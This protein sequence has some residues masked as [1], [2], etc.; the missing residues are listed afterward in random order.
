MYPMSDDVVFFG[1]KSVLSLNSFVGF[2]A[3][4][5]VLKNLLLVQQKGVK[6]QDLEKVLEEEGN[7]YQFIKNHIS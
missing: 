3:V 7:G 5:Q 6:M 1:R 4:A 2:V